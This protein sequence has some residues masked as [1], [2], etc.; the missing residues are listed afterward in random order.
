[1][2][3]TISL[4]ARKADLKHLVDA[5][6]ISVLNKSKPELAVILHL[7]YNMLLKNFYGDIEW[8]K[9]SVAQLKELCLQKNIPFLKSSNKSILI[10]LLFSTAKIRDI[11]SEIKLLREREYNSYFLSLRRVPPALQPGTTARLPQIRPNQCECHICTNRNCFVASNANVGANLGANLDHPRICDSLHYKHASSDSV[12]KYIKHCTNRG[13]S[14]GAAG[15][16]A[17]ENFIRDDDYDE[18]YDRW[19]YPLL[20]VAGRTSS[21]INNPQSTISN[22]QFSNQQFG[23]CQKW[24]QPPS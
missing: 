6:G 7:Y 16:Y 10:A 2:F 11:Q 8:Y 18:A 19:V 20:G 5:I 12:T 15:V 22:Q 14:V 9:L 17:F 13:I 24:R 21:P 1:M 4:S 3:L 23:L